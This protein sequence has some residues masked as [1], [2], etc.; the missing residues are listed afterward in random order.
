MKLQ[1]NIQKKFSSTQEGSPEGIRPDIKTEVSPSR[2]IHQR[3]SK[4]NH[5]FLNKRYREDEAHLA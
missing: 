1:F 2:P 3:Q 4:T 5:A